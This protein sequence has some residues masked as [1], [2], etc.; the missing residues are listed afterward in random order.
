MILQQIQCPLKAN[1]PI[2]F[3]RAHSYIV[4]KYSLELPISQTS[5]FSKGIH[6]YLRLID[7]LTDS[8]MR[9][10]VVTICIDQPL[11]EKAFNQP[12]AGFNGWFGRNISFQVI[13]FDVFQIFYIYIMVVKF[14]HRTPHK[15]I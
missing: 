14:T 8:V 3:F 2:I 6:V 15:W 4:G 10:L 11:Y 7:Y 12:D 5:T 13:Q 9:S 1:Y